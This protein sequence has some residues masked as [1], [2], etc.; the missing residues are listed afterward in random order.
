MQTEVATH[1]EIRQNRASQDRA[2]VAGTRIRVQDIYA[3]SE[4][5]GLSPDQIVAELPHLTLGQVH[6]ALAYYF[7]H[8]EQIRQEFREDDEFVEMLRRQTGPG[9][10][11]Q[12]LKQP[13]PNDAVSS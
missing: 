6:A 3:M 2:Y 13:S 1:I 5:Q 9:P 12:R 11:E 4:V 8:R 7:D 10:L